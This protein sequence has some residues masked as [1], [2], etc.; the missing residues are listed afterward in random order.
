MELNPFEIVVER[1]TTE[2]CIELHM[3]LLRNKGEPVKSSAWFR[4]DSRRKWTVVLFAQKTL[5]ILASFFEDIYI[6]GDAVFLGL[7]A[8]IIKY[9]GRTHDLTEWSV[10][11][12]LTNGIA[13][14]MFKILNC[15]EAIWQT[16]KSSSFSLTHYVQYQCVPGN[17]VGYCRIILIFWV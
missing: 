1:F 12:L 8:S 6:S 13:M 10:L 9:L 2:F 11:Y 17:S 14:S 16:Q 15:F 7:S 5:N 4:P 3:R